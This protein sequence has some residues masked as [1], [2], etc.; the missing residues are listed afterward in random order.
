[1]RRLRSKNCSSEANH[2]M[3]EAD[4]KYVEVGPKLVILES[5]L[6][7]AKERAKVSELQCGALEEEL[8]IVTSNLKS[9]KAALGKYS[10]K[11]DKYIEDIKLLSDK[12]KEAETHAEF[13]GMVPKLKET[14]HDLEKKLA[15]VKEETGASIRHWIRHLNALNCV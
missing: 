6:E 4:C 1:M 9:L 13:A 14:I 12:L 8:K 5:E 3:E 7:R 11:E 10:E 15:Q 2:N